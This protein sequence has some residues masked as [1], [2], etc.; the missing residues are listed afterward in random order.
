MLFKMTC[1]QCNGQMDMDDARSFMFCPY[2]G[3]K[4]ANLSQKIEIDQQ[5]NVSGTVMYKTDFSNQPNLYVSYTAS[6]PS[7][8]MLIT[9]QSVGVK[10]ALLISGQDMTFRLPEGENLIAI[11]IGKIN[12]KRTVMINS[13]KGPVRIYASWAKHAQINIDTPL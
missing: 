1:P 9:I 10:K 5:V 8:R 6:D 7:V 12:Y 2:C 4:V 11:K 13:A 3:T